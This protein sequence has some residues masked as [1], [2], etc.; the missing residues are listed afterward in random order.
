MESPHFAERMALPWLDAARYSDTHGYSIDDHRDM[1]AWRDWVIH[2]FQTNQPYDQ[3]LTR[4]NRRRPHSRT[5]RPTRS[6]P[7]ASCATA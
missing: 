6:P 2:A 7:P 5:P 4:T 1:W 3:F